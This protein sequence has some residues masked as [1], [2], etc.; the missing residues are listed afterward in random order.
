VVSAFLSTKLF[1][2]C[3]GKKFFRYFLLEI[4][5]ALNN[6]LSCFCAMNV[7]VVITPDF[8]TAFRFF[9]IPRELEGGAGVFDESVTVLR[10]GPLRSLGKILG[11]GRDFCRH[12][13]GH[14]GAGA[15][16]SCLLRTADSAAEDRE[17]GMS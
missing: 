16:T 1:W 4:K 2:V 13:R 9:E 7:R 12:C 5:G 3:L 17:W 14:S 15:P 10:A 6:M 8:D 11:T